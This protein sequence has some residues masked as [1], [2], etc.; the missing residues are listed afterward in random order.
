M[1]DLTNKKLKIY[2]D[3]TAVKYLNAPKSPNEMKDMQTLWEMLKKGV[4]DV[5]ISYVVVEELN[6]I[7][8]PI[9]RSSLL[10]HLNKIDC[11]LVVKSEDIDKIVK[12]VLQ[13][14]ILTEKNIKACQHLACAVSAN[15]DCIVSY[16]YPQLVNIKSIKGVR[17]VSMF[18]R[19]DCTDIVT[20][21]SLIQTS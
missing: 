9:L 12:T 15:C 2:L 10:S 20:A 11:E 4:Y 19:K 13:F 3:A 1:D 6:Q 8:N 16:D 5:A 17:V 7:S 21:R 18:H 14:D